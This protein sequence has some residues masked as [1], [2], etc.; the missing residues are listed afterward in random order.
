MV[1]RG[2]LECQW[3]AQQ[4]LRRTGAADSCGGEDDGGAVAAQSFGRSSGARVVVAVTASPEAPSWPHDADGE[5]R[6]GHGGSSGSGSS[7]TEPQQQPPQAP[8][9]GL[10]DG[11]AGWRV[12][13]LIA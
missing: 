3:M 11:L 12:G 6:G 2:E 7:P 9:V 4:S 1:L 13:W 10:L 8:G 5:G